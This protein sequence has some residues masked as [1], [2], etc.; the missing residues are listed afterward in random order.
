LTPTGSLADGS[1]GQPVI[2]KRTSN[3]WYGFK[4][5]QYLMD[6]PLGEYTMDIT[7]SD[8]S[9]STVSVQYANGS[10]NNVRFSPSNTA[11][12]GIDG[13]LINIVAGGS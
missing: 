1:T 2:F 12:N 10:T 8:P 11:P 6:I 3:T 4:E 9:G 13:P 7:A 5:G